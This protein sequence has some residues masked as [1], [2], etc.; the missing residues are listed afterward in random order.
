MPG[1]GRDFEAAT[2]A[3]RRSAVLVKEKGQSQRLE[4]G[5]PKTARSR[6]IDL[7]AQ[8]LVGW[9]AVCDTGAIVPGVHPSA[10]I[11]GA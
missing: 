2:L 9:T 3:V 4:V 1:D 6:V 11:R 5:L 7:D 8:T 10:D